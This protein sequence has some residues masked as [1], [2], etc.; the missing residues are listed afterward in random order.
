M[1][2]DWHLSRNQFSFLMQT[3]ELVN[4]TI[5][6]CQYFISLFQPRLGPKPFCVPKFE[7]DSTDTSATENSASEALNDI[8]TPEESK[9]K[10]PDDLKLNN[11]KVPELK[12]RIDNGI[13]HEQNGTAMNGMNHD[14]TPESEVVFTVVVT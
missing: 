9:R 8:K 11:D 14:H 4:L 10:V 13:C 6:D 12:S 2:I 1:C 7:N 5:Q 3:A